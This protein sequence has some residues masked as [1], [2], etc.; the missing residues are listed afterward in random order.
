M[1]TERLNEA[2][3]QPSLAVPRISEDGKQ[4]EQRRVDYPEDV[5]DLL[6]FVSGSNRNPFSAL[7]R[8]PAPPRLTR[9]A[10]QAFE[11]PHPLYRYRT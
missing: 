2:I 8:S 4:A 5:A 7:R 10:N 6:G 1:F 9:A 3:N 11:A